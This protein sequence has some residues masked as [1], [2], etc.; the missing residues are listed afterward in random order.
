MTALSLVFA[1]VALLSPSDWEVVPTQKEGQ[2][3]YFS[4]SRAERFARMDNPADRVKLAALGGTQKPLE[5]KWTGPTNSVV[6][7]EIDLADGGDRQAFMLTNRTSV[8]ITNLE[9]GRR[10]VWSVADEHGDCAVAT[11]VTEPDAPRFLRAGG[12]GNFRDLGGWKTTDGRRVRQ[13]RI[14]RS[15]GL[16]FSSKTSGNFFR[17]K[18]E[19]GPRRV[20]EDGLRTLSADFRIRTDLELRTP[21]ETAGMV[22]TIVPGAHWVNVSYAAYGFIG[23][24]IRGR[25]PLR[26]IFPNF[27]KEENYPILMHCS[28]GRDRTGTLAFLLNGLLGVSEDDLCRDWEST[29]FFDAGSRFTSERIT[30]LLDY[31][32]TY[33]GETINAKIE[34]YF[35]SCGISVE[36]IESFRS[37][38]LEKPE[39][40]LK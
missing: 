8:H 17:K 6:R 19:L 18:V 33:S 10:Y 34:A 9:V 25:E 24:E 13:N 30:G 12:V 5:L 22:D 3:A 38:M 37:L 7:L 14:F 4:G 1:A 32:K 28:G 35:R 2:K 11:F 40:E 16:R 21:Q 15:A 23:N 39:E 27:L 29:I 31:L 26:K 36:E 20:T